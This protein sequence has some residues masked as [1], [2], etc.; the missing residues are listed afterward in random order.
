MILFQ[1]CSGCGKENNLVDT[2]Q[3]GTMVTVETHCGNP[4]CKEKKFMW[5]SQP[6]IEGTKAAA[7]N[8]LLSFAILLACASATKCFRVF[9]HMELM[10]H[11]IR[12]FF[13]HQKVS[14]ANRSHVI[15]NIYAL[16]PLWQLWY[17]FYSVPYRVK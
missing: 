1:L 15:L 2:N 17:A 16:L 3:Q 6:R 10:C 11:S 12:Q 7:G 14:V 13:R 8:I 9:S 5:Q 4:S